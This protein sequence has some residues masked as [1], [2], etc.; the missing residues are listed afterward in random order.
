MS[1]A[2]KLIGSTSRNSSHS[3]ESR[4]K[5]LFEVVVGLYLID[6]C[7]AASMLAL[8]LRAGVAFDFSMLGAGM[9]LDLQFWLFI[10]RGMPGSQPN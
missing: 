4:T 7:R 2:T 9:T 1:P 8:M 6:W 10:T 3:N 5:Y